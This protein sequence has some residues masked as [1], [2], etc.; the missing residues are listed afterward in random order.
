MISVPPEIQKI[1]SDFLVLFSAP[2]Y[3]NALILMIYSMHTSFE[4]AIQ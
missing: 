4:V 2:V 1:F 3:G